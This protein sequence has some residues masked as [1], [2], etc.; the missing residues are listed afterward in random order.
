MKVSIV[1]AYSYLGYFC[2][3]QNDKPNALL[4]C[5]KALELDPQNATANA[6]LKAIK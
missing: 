3:I 5:N 4:Y 6:V 1:E 2:Y